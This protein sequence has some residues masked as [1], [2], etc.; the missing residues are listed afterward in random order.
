MVDTNRTAV[1]TKIWAT[2]ESNVAGEDAA[3]ISATMI[4]VAATEQQVEKAQ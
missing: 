2:K 1:I 3:A 4:P